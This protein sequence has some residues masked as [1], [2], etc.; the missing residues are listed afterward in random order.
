ME[1]IARSENEFQQPTRARERGQEV[2]NAT[3]ARGCIR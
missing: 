1:D 2:K 3:G